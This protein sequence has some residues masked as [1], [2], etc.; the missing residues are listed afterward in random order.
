M[1]SENDVIL[2]HR[3]NTAIS[4]SFLEMGSMAGASGHNALTGGAIDNTKSGLF[5]PATENDQYML[6]CKQHP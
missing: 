3:L 2:R 1:S 6:N 5:K 4:T